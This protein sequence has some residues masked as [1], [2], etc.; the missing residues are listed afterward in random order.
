MVENTDIFK[1]ETVMKPHRASVEGFQADLGHHRHTQLVGTV[2]D[3][4]VQ[5]GAHPRLQDHHG[6]RSTYRNRS[7]RSLNQA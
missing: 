7:Y 2:N 4:S 6:D 1:P 3:T 5:Q